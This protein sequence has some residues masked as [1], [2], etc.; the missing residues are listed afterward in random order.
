MKRTVTEILIEVE[1]TVCVL[2]TKQSMADEGKL[3][4]AA[5]DAVVCPSCGSAFSPSENLEKQ[6][7]LEKQNEKE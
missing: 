1:E 5:T 6:N 2:R 7:K 3:N 4:V